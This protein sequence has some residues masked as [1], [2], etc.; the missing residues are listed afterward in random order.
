M[1][2][3]KYLVLSIP[4]YRQFHTRDWGRAGCSM[5]ASDIGEKPIRYPIKMSGWFETAVGDQCLRVMEADT[6]K[7]ARK[8]TTCKVHCTCLL[9][10]GLGTALYIL[11]RSKE[12]ICY[13][14]KV[15]QM[16][17]CWFSGMKLRVFAKNTKWNCAYPPRTGNEIARLCQLQGEKLCST[18]SEPVCICQVQGVLCVFIR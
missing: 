7:G 1:C 16:K 2:I 15:W 5:P 8:G 4:I 14:R 10:M 12:R 9:S 18:G 3:Y 13:V 11:A 6:G 17:L